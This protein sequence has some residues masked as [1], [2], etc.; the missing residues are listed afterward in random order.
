MQILRK[1]LR[2][3]LRHQQSINSAARNKHTLIPLTVSFN[4]INFSEVLTA[5]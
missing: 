4:E 5:T 3:T 2:S 1:V